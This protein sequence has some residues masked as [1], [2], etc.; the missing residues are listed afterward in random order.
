MV[1]IEISHPGKLPPNVRRQ[2]I[3]CAYFNGG[4]WGLG[5]GLTGTTLLFYLASSYGAK[6]MALSWLLAAPALVGVLR[7]FTPLWLDRVGSRHIFCT[8]MFAVSALVL[9]G[10]PVLSAPTSFHR[11][12]NRSLR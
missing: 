2:S 5:S 9:L 3:V 11:Q 6:G 1:G 10:L 8:R 4:L 7:L 12:P